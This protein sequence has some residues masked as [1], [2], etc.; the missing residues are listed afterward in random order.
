MQEEESSTLVSLETDC[1]CVKGTIEAGEAAGQTEKH[2]SKT[3]WSVSTELV[4]E[5]KDPRDRPNWEYLAHAKANGLRENLFLRD[6]SELSLGHRNTYQCR[7]LSLET[8][9]NLH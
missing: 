8:K 1:D 9:R 2:M 6:Y 3:A 5:S 4:V 7:I